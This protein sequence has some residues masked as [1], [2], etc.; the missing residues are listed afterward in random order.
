MIQT[1]KTQQQ[2]NQ[3]DELVIAFASCHKQNKN[4]SQIWNSIANEKPDL[5]LWLGDVIYADTADSGSSLL[6]KPLELL[7]FSEFQLTEQIFKDKYQQTKT[8]KDY[9]ALLKQIELKNKENQNS[10][11]SKSVDGIWDDHDYGLN[12]GGAEFRL[13]DISRELFL[14]FL[15]DSADSKRRTQ[16]GGIYSS[17]WVG[18]DQSVKIIL[19]D[20]RFE[21]THLD[22]MSEHQWRWIEKELAEEKPAHKIT[23]LLSSEQLLPVDKIFKE[24]W[25]WGQYPE[26]RERLLRLLSKNNRVSYVV[27]SGDIHSGGVY[28][29]HCLAHT[30]ESGS[31]LSLTEITASGLT[32]SCYD[33]LP[34]G[35]CWFY[36]LFIQSP[37]TQVGALF[38]K[39]NYGTLKIRGLSQSSTHAVAAVEIHS[40]DGKSQS[41]LTVTTRNRTPMS[42]QEIESFIECERGVK[43]RVPF[44][45]YQRIV[46]LLIFGSILFL[47]LLLWYR[48][49]RRRRAMQTLKK[50]K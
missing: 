31:R 3:K 15:G 45:D 49:Y 13:R 41:K 42:Q 16:A 44:L 25:G 48:D 14:D 29:S 32:H 12:D 47:V 18:Q 10:I 26:S 28:H 38:T 34:F 11:S 8:N 27:M 22:L 21:R 37:R 1:I 35:L 5:F 7:G 6:K 43:S 19:M 39:R 30:S 9:S 4:S 50:N 20:I 23:I 46:V 2:D 33:D 36:T 17:F 24:K 40:Q